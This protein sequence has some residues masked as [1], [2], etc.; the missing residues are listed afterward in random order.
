MEDVESDAREAPPYLALAMHE[1]NLPIHDLVA[2]QAN[3][4]ELLTHL[5][6]LMPQVVQ[7]TREGVCWA[8]TRWTV[9]GRKATKA[10]A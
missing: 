3:N 4:Q 6:E 1:C 9:V 8:F 5:G 7:E 10:P 2:R